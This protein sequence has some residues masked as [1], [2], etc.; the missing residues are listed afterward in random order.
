MLSNYKSELSELEQQVAEKRLALGGA[1]FRL[2]TLRAEIASEDRRP[3]PDIDK[4]IERLTG[5]PPTPIDLTEVSRISTDDELAERAS[6]AVQLLAEISQI[7]YQISAETARADA[8]TEFREILEKTVIGDLPE[9]L[10]GKVAE[11]AELSLLLAQGITRF[12]I[13]V[14]VIFLV[15]IL[16]G[17]Y[18]YSLR[19]S[20]FYSA[21]A[22]AFIATLDRKTDLGGWGADLLPE[23]IDFGKHP[24]TPA[25]YMIDMFRAYFA[26][27][28]DGKDKKSKKETSED[29]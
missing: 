5:E 14:V 12:G 18:R 4:A 29:G 7:E 2:R 9:Y 23:S 16:V 10:T 1:S 19:L 20:A 26:S 28:S 25:Q 11:P 22:D 8:L 13:L 24:V 3:T 6:N 27:R 15:Q 17:I 21:R